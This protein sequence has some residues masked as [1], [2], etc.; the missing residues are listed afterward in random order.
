MAL[1]AIRSGS[2]EPVLPDFARQLF[3]AEE[4]HFWFRSRNR[5]IG[6]VIAKLTAALPGGFR[7]LEVGCGNGNVLRLLEQVCHKGAV[8]GVDLL[9]E[10]LHY[11]R[12]RSSCPV[13]A[14]DVGSLPFPQPFD[15]IGM[16]D[17]LEHIPDDGKALQD[18]HKALTPEGA[19]V[20][21]VPAHMGL[22]SYA[23]TNA[24]H[25]RRYNK[26]KLA[27][28][29]QA[30]GFAIEYMTEFMTALFPLMWLGRRLSSLRQRPGQDV[31]KDR[32]NFLRELRIVPG[33]NTLLTALLAW[34]APLIARR[35]PLPLGTSLLAVARKAA[36][37]LTAPKAA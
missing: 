15:V 16:F 37:T 4:R 14:A 34:E 19:V 29:L 7:V 28:V 11:A 12:Q 22:W 20:L 18:V 23:D 26:K 33:L 27:T 36:Q 1:S 9:E 31:N 3:E 8:Y 5:V 2:A 32:A 6:R 25:C 10:R 21:T 17:V 24:G 35:C 13:V 30:S